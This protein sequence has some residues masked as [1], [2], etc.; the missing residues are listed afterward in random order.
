MQQ[1]PDMLTEDFAGNS[2]SIIVFKPYSILKW[3]YII[4]TV[5]TEFRLGYERTYTENSDLMRYVGLA[6]VQKANDMLTCL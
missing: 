6:F 3:W 2:F 1:E 5:W 4:H